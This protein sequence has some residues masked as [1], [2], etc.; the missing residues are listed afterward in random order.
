MLLNRT[1]TNTVVRFSFLYN[2]SKVSF[3]KHTLPH[4][5][6]REKSVWISIWVFSTDH[7]NVQYTEF[8]ST[9]GAGDSAG[10]PGLRS[11][12]VLATCKPPTQTGE[13]PHGS[14]VTLLALRLV[15]SSYD[16]H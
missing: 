5:V 10:Q 12:L 11:L 7:T 1:A 6:Q 16:T 2:D 8:R 14:A 13:T 15:I 3:L 9:G 4:Y